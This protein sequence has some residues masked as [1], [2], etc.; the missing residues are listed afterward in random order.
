MNSQ[1]NNIAYMLAHRLNDMPLKKKLT[2]IVSFIAFSVTAFSY[3]LDAGREWVVQRAEQ[4]ENAVALAE[5]VSAISG[6]CQ[7]LRDYESTITLTDWSR[8]PAVAYVRIAPKGDIPYEL[9]NSGHKAAFS[10][11]SVLGPSW[12][13]GAELHLGMVYMPGKARIALYL[14]YASVV[15]LFL[16]AGIIYV[17]QVII[18]RYILSPLLHL[19][20]VMNKITV[21]PYS[22]YDIDTSRDD[23]I[24]KINRAFESLVNT[25]KLRQEEMNLS[26]SQAIESEEKFKDLA[27]L[28]PIAI[29]EAGSTGLVSFMN[30]IGLSIYGYASGDIAKGLSVSEL[31][32]SKTAEPLNL[33][34]FTG[35]NEIEVRPL[36]VWGLRKGGAEFHV[37]AYLSPIYKG[38]NF[39]GI[40][41]VIVDISDKMEMIDSLKQAKRD[42]ENSDKLK[43]AFLA[44]MSHEIRTPMNSIIGFADMLTEEGLSIDERKEYINYINN[45]GKVL[46]NLIDDIIDIAKIEAGQIQTSNVKFCINSIIDELK[47]FTANELKRMGKLNI[48]LLSAKSGPDDLAIES[49]PFRLRQIITNLLVNA[50]KFTEEGRIE[51]GYTI[52]L[53]EAQRLVRFYVR[54]TGIG[55]PD[56]KHEEVFDRF[57]KLPHAANKLYGGTGLGLAISRRLAELLGGEISLQSKEGQGSLFSLSLPIS[58]SDHGLLS[59]KIE[60]ETFKKTDIDWSSKTILVAEDEESNFKFV[61]AA[62]KKTKAEIIWVQN[63]KLAVEACL[64]NPSISVVLMDMKMPVMNGFEATREIRSKLPSRIPIIAQTAFAMAGEKEKSLSAGC[65]GY[66]AKPIKTRDLIEIIGRIMQ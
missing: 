53:K 35:A 34:D 7:S 52:E 36:H 6:S 49:D 12:A 27:H 44:N 50:A 18:G 65:D 23:E 63:G 55:I 24:G 51:L 1:K 66:I 46:L 61:K 48:E 16:L 60:S 45:S 13:N 4:R 57:T 42:A 3:L 26:I 39:C 29:F 14:I 38:G 10:A 9:F 64:T 33:L 43:S 37:N 25:V 41:G 32:K 28:S 2:V 56:D 58:Q 62:L 54:D 59:A 8:Y 11:K 5:L 47:A 15:F 30:R 22:H 20:E 21:N 19:S 17:S 31:F 40:R